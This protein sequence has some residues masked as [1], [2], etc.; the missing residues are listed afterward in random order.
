MVISLE[1][2]CHITLCVGKALRSA[3]VMESETI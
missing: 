1:D 2:L 3:D